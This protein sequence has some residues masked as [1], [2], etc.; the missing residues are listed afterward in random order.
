MPQ[1][2]AKPHRPKVHY[3][4]ANITGDTVK[5]IAG[6]TILFELS[7]A[8]PAETIL[9]TFADP[10]FFSK[11]RFKSGDETIDV[12]HNL[13]HPTTYH[14]QLLGHGVPVPGVESHE[15]GGS[16]EPDSGA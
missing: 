13:T 7:G 8:G 16:I 12:T 14:C 5:V 15:Q 10:Q 6:D 9:I 2:P 4:G 11:A 1:R 3:D